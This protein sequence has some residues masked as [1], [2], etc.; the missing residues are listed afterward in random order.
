MG[1]AAYSYTRCSGSSA[2]GSAPLEGDVLLRG[3]FRTP[4]RDVL[5]LERDDFS[6][7]L[8]FFEEEEEETACQA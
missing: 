5:L 4:Q 8:D 3:A 2:S 6:D 7:D 1:R